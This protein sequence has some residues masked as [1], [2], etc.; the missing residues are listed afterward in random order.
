MSSHTWVIGTIC[1]PIRKLKTIMRIDLPKAV[2]AV[3]A[4]TLPGIAYAQQISPGIAARAVS[5]ILILGLAIMLGILVRSWWVGVT[6]AMPSPAAP[7][8]A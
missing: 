8:S 4:V 7:G 6:H 2:F 3:S 1:L 5:P